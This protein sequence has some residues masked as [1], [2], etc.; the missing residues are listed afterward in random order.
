M[1]NNIKFYE[2][3]LPDNLNLGNIVA[4]DTEAMGL[5][6]FRDRLCLVQLSSGDGVGHIVRFEPHNYNKANN[7][8]KLL[9]DP[10]VLKIMHFARFDMAILQK[11][12]GVKV[13]NVYCT[14]IASKIYRPQTFT[15]NRSGCRFR[16]GFRWGIW[17]R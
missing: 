13:K 3:D 5:N 9:K 1:K 10:K 12:L 17:N 7:L 6:N 15:G 2:G 11:Y 14:K 4:I 8:K 16:F